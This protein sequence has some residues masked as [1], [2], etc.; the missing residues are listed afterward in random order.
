MRALLLMLFLGACAGGSEGAAGDEDK[1]EDERE[2]DP[3]T[4]VEVA[5]VGRGSVGD[6]IGASAV[7]ESE[8]QASLVPE[9]QGIVTGIYA[10]EGDTVKKGQLLA[11]VAS[12]TLDAA[13][14]RAG[15]ELERASA[16]A[17]AAERL[18]GQGAISKTEVDTARRALSG[19]RTANEEASRTKGFTRLESPIDGTVAART[20]RYGELAAGQPAFT[21][22]DLTRLRVIV[23]LP[24]RDLAKVRVGLPATLTSAYDAAITGAGSVERVAPVVDPASGT[25]RVT[26]RIGD[27]TEVPASGAPTEPV[28]AAVSPLR[29]GQFAS[30]KIEVDRHEGVLTAPRRALVWEEG[31]S[32]VFTVVETTK[33]EEEK[34][35]AADK[36]KV[37]GE[38]P[39]EPE[40]PGFLAKLFGGEEEEKK[41]TELPGPWRKA[42]RVEVAVGYEE[43]EIAE[44]LSGVEEGASVVVIGNQALRDGARVRLP[45]DPTIAAKEDEKG[46]AA[47]PAVA[48]EA[49]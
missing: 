31:R 4:L 46:E 24:E 41:E 25:F 19:A 17:E 32:Y 30:V 29:P 26:V 35:A 14:Q 47:G 3:R 10:E 12:P 15:A 5:A 34:L 40:E 2:A 6:H 23:N 16:D 49:G 42:K 48:T 27:P 8:A 38:A 28:G 43:G 13:Y 37:E 1:A 36:P 18:F 22:V 11:V 21:I 20:L 45:S 9:T 39:A 7:V 44:L 33:E